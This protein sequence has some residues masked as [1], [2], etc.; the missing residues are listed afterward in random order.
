MED[1]LGNNDK[2]NKNNKNFF[3]K[4]CTLI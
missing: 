4:L 1:R 2:T 3:D